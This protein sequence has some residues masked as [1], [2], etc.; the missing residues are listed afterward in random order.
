MVFFQRFT[1][2]EDASQSICV[3]LTNMEAWLEGILSSFFGAQLLF[4]IPHAL[5]FMCSWMRSQFI[6]MV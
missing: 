2:Y 6:P 3:E 1:N 5:S 4:K